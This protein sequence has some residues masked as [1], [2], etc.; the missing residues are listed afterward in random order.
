MKRVKT[1][2]GHRFGVDLESRRLRSS[3]GQMA[4]FDCMIAQSGDEKR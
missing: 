1:Q 3:F 4:R 2:R